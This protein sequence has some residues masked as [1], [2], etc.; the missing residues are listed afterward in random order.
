MEK[1]ANELRESLLAKNYAQVRR[2]VVEKGP[3]WTGDESLFVWVLV[4]DV[5]PDEEL[6]WNSIEPLVEATRDESRNH[7]RELYPY[8]KVKREREWHEM[9]AA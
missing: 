4:D 7:Y 6:S 5:L 1:F 8:V 2:V 9:A 3:D